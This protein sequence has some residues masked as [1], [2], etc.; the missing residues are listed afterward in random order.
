MKIWD[1]HCHARGEETGDQVLRWMD[2]AKID[3]INLFSRYPAP[4]GGEFRRKDARESIDHIARAQ[5]ADPDRIFGLIWAEPRAPGMVEEIE[6]G[7]GEKGL[8]GVKMIPDHWSPGDDILLPIYE[9]MQALGRPIQFHSGIL[10]GFGDSS[11]FCQPVL[12]EPLV[13]F[14]GLRFSLAHIGWP[15][16]D[17][18]LAVFGRFR[19]AAGY[20]T[21]RCQM[22]IDTCRGTPDAWR[23]E[24]LRKAVPFCGMSRL[25]FGVDCDPASLPGNAPAHVAKDLTIL[26]DIMGLTQ[27]QVQTFFWGACEAFYGG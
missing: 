7:I 25:M 16:V 15:W 22:W 2:E 1:C 12:Y 24:A 18:C 17:E 9:K 10:Y 3:R 23:E 13:H 19:A 20:R 26:R 4:V 21:D 6:Y 8:R 14:P 11:R 5:S 27:E